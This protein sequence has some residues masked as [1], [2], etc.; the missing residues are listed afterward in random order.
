MTAS[1]RLFGRL[2]VCA[3]A[4]TSLG[5][6]GRGPA[7][8]AASGKSIRPITPPALQGSVLG[9]RVTEE[10]VVRAVRRFHR[11][12]ADQVSLYGLRGEADLLEATLQ[13]S[14]FHDPATLRD[15]RIRAGLVTQIG[16]TQPE[17]LHVDR[18]AVEATRANGQRLFVWVRGGRVFVLAVRDDFLRPRDLLRQMVTVG[19]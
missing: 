3:V 9:L 11:S 18:I 8:P 7:L 12:Y 17:T 19:A 15:P 5:S 10:N 13:V 6:C 2:V 14:R 16:E 4:L 1:R